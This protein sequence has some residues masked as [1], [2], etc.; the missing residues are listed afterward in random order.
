MDSARYSERYVHPKC[1]C[2]VRDKDLL[3][4]NT[5]MDFLQHE[6]LCTIPDN[7]QKLMAPYSKD[8]DSAKHRQRQPD[9]E[10]LEHDRKREV[11]VKVLELRDKLEDEG[12]ADTDTTENHMI[13]C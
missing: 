12:Y 10:I 4:N 3:D 8:W 2:C 11:E 13:R 1:Y 9:P 6:Q 7:V 5:V